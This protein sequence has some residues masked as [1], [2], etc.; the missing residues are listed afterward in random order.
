M[1]LR[2]LRILHIANF[3]QFKYAAWYM[4]LDAKLSLGFS[5]LGHAVY[6]FSQRDIARAENLFKSKNL[7]RKAMIKALL[8]TVDNFSPE[9]VVLGHSEM[10]DVET[11]R[12][13]RAKLPSTPF[14][15]WYCDP[16]FREYEDVY[17]L[18]LLAERSEIVD[19]IFTTSGAYVLNKIV[20]GCC[21]VA[22]VPNWVHSGCESGKAFANS[23]LSNDLIYAGND[24]NLAGRKALLESLVDSSDGV[25]FALYQAL[26][27]RRI[28]GRAYYEQLGQSLMGLSLSRR[29]DVPWYTSDRMQQEMGNGVCTISPKTPGLTELFSEDEVVW[30]DHEDEILEKVLWYKSN[31][32]EARLIAERGWHAAHERCNAKRVAQFM[33]DLAFDHAL[34]EDYEWSSQII[35]KH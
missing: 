33:L 1:G 3:N 19:V 15:M 4:N 23:N 25:K 22:H 14:V 18:P 12:E 26:G 13:L 11:L 17:D 10:L 9:L 24:Y 2:P 29:F 31:E 27:N 16:L 5:Q 32:T 20:Q 6:N 21:K 34:S 8:E 28:H 35:K 7:G 30:F